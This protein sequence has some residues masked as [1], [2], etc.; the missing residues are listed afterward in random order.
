MRTPVTKVT[1][2]V[3]L[4]WQTYILGY[5]Y[6]QVDYST[7]SLTRYT[8]VVTGTLTFQTTVQEWTVDDNTLEL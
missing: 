4:L 3:S 8:L 5:L 2:D 7:P 1:K 6:R